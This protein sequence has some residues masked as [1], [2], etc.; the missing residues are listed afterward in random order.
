M[1]ISCMDISTT[2][3]EGLLL[4]SPQK[5]EDHRGFFSEV[6]RDDKLKEHGFTRDFVQDNHSLSVEQGVL[7]GLH[8]Q[9][10]P[11][12]Q[13][14]LIRVL[15][16]SILDVAVDIRAGSPTFGEYYSTELSAENW[17]QLLVPHGFAH[18]FVTL[19]PNTEVLYKCTSYYAPEHDAGILWNCAD[20]NID[21]GKIKGPIL[22][23]KDA[24]LSPLSETKLVFTYEQ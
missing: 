24:A 5:H 8:Y 3:L 17:K 2:K 11:F 9:K 15:R 10:P 19:E 12:A 4:I 20:I 13:D 14:K 16:G 23:E 6:F 21:W 7:R 18:G 1:Q 22:S